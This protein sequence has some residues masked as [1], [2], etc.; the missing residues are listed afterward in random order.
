MGRGTAMP[1]TI[2]SILYGLCGTGAG[3]FAVWRYLKSSMN[4]DALDAKAQ[5]IIKNLQEML[6]AEW[7]K[8]QKLSDSIDR[9]A[10]ERNEAVQ[11]VGRLEGTIEVLSGQVNTLK[12]EVERLERQ[13]T[14]LGGQLTDIKT[15]LD[16]LVRDRKGAA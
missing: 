11:A 1:E 10:K 3:G 7:D 2:Q 15:V 14:T 9:V 13:N 6:K 4:T 8:N 12:N 16:G 5:A